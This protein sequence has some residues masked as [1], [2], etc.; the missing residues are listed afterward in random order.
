[1]RH[2]CYRRAV[3][4]ALALL[5]GIAV[6]AW[7]ALLP[8]PSLASPTT[9]APADLFASAEAAEASMRFA[10]AVQLYEELLRLAPTYSKAPRARARLED[11]RA[12]S[13]GDFLPLQRLETVRRDPALAS[14]AEAIL[15][16]E[17]DAGSFPPG[18]VRAEARLLCGTAWLGRLENPSRAIAPLAAVLADESADP[19]LRRLALSQLVDARRALG[20]VTGA[21]AD[22][23]AHPDLVP[24][25]RDTVHREARRVWI[26]RGAVAVVGAMLVVGLAALARLARAAGVGATLK[27]A[28]RPLSALFALWL[29]GMGAL[30]ARG[31]DA[32]DPR[33]FFLLGIGVLVVD[34]AG[35]AWAAAAR[36]GL[37]FG[38]GP[39]LRATLCVASVLAAAFLS[40]DASDVAYLDSFGL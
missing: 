15:A 14:S 6:A 13:E 37:G 28:F 8:S 10:E 29:G 21:V 25:L 9:S 39:S 16:L 11:L 7:L 34:I 35:R 3:P 36:L 24:A 23:D 2:R 32:S 31:Y 40:L 1:M 30:L 20:D 26:R 5:L 38:V 19:L 18:R 12:H 4:R 17:R 27:L 33:P 22:V